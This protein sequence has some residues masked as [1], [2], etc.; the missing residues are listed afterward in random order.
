ML[1]IG[2]CFAENIGE[3]LFRQKFKVKINPNGILFN[4]LSIANCLNSAIKKLPF[5]EKLLVEREN[6]FF[7]YDH[8]S[9]ISAEN[10][11][12]LLKK[13]DVITE[14]THQ[15]LRSADYLIITFGSAHV[16][17]HQ[18]LKQVVANCHKQDSVLFQKRLLEPEDIVKLFSDL[19]REIKNLN[20]KIRIIF[21]VSPVKYLKDGVEQNRLSK[22]S[23]LL[24]VNK[25]VSQNENCFYFPA[26]ELVNDDLRDYRFYKEDMAHPN[27]QAIDYVWKKFAETF[28]SEKTRE[29][30]EH[31]HKLNLAMEHKPMNSH[32][33]EA[34]KLQD[35]I[36]KQK[37]QI[38]K[39]DPTIEF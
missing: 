15:S 38:L 25:L 9:S 36:K 22:S 10:K 5:N 4:P 35:Y 13:I 21:T 24:S 33:T 12:D 7:S 23:L 1:M 18:T 39:L 34:A 6:L 3:R 17:E 11:N 14:E 30:N 29:L 20:P 16:F 8:H 31:I 27:E 26:Y 19:I 32:R 37:D 2:S 28:F